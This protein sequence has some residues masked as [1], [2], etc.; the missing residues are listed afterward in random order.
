MLLGDLNEFGLDFS[1]V[2]P[3]RVYIYP[4][5]AYFNNQSIWHS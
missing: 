5:I 2:P 3:N 4:S 1:L